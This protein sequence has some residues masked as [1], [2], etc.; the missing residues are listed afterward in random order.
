MRVWI[1]VDYFGS[2]HEICVERAKNGVPIC[3]EN[4]GKGGWE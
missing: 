2:Q 4:S 3:E 1:E